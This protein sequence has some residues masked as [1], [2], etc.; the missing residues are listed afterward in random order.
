MNPSQ[1]DLVL[2]H[3]KRHKSITSWEAIQL[4]RIT[5]LASVIHLLKADGYNIFTT[6]EHNENKTWAK[7]TLLKNSK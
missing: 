4:F 5:R 2:S 1:K 6:K 3:L 7:Y